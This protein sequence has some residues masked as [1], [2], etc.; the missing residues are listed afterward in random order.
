MRCW[1]DME[2]APPTGVGG[3]GRKQVVI[4]SVATPCNLNHLQVST[5]MFPL[6]PC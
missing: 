5:V 1:V 3:T 2:L 6:C 4:M